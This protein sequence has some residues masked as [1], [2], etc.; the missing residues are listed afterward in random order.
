MWPEQKDPP[1]QAKVKMSGL[2]KPGTHSI[3]HSAEL[4]PAEGGRGANGEKRSRPS[5]SFWD[6]G[7]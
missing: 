1:F 5:T 6:S 7:I 2:M 3:A 4:G